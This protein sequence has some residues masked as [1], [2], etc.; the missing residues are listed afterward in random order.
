M[1]YL[2]VTHEFAVHPEIKAGINPLEN[3]KIF[4][5]RIFIQIKVPDVYPGRVHVRYIRGIARIGVINI[6]IMGNVISMQLPVGRDRNII[7][8]FRVEPGGQELIIRKMNRFIIFEFPY[9][10]QVFKV[11]G[12]AP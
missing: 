11:F 12:I 4:F 7:P 3:G 8:P 9:A 1:A 6:G 5:V 10:I 2:A